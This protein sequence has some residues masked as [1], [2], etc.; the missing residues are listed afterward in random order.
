MSM[1]S[2]PIHELRMTYR[3]AA[4]VDGSVRVLSTRLAERG[5][6][7]RPFSRKITGVEMLESAVTRLEHIN[8]VS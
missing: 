5:P 7:V 3:L 8:P 2:L 4:T 1:L 6:A